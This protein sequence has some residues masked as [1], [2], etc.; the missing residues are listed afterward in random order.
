MAIAS[1]CLHNKFGHCKFRETCRHPHNNEIC[2]ET[3][4]EINKCSKR[5]PKSCRYFK[6]F[7]RCKFGDFC[8]FV[9]RELKNDAKEQE[10][11]EVKARLVN[12][13]NIVKVK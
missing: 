10:L 2:E 12:L 4:C 3:N 11:N 8:S 1:I 13:E 6:D 5:H 9:H 7:N